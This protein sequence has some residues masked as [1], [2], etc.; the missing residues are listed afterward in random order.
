MLVHSD[1]LLYMVGE[2][3]RTHETHQT[4]PSCLFCDAQLGSSDRGYLMVNFTL[5]M[6]LLIYDFRPQLRKS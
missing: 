1:D 3:R 2:E 6:Y 4:A 5:V